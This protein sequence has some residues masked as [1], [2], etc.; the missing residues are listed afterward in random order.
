M[1]QQDEARSGHSGLWRV[2]VPIMAL[3]AGLLFGTSAALAENES[4]ESHPES[5]AGLITERNTAVEQ[6]AD[7][8]ATLQT[9]ID[10]IG[11]RGRPVAAGAAD[12]IAPIVGTAAVRGPAVQVVL[13][14][15]GYTLE[16][17]P[18]GYTVDDVV[19]HQQDVQG[20]I[21]ALWAGGAEAM[22]V[23][24][25]RIIA[26]SA[27][28]CVGNTLYLQG[29][30]Y[31]P[32]Y[33]ITAIGHP[34]TMMRVLADDPT[35]SNYAAWAEILGLGYEVSDIGETE[36]PAFTGTVRAQHASPLGPRPE[37]TRE[38]PLER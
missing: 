23:Q 6:L 27:V 21:N 7:R 34:G 5:L 10:E 35:V 22:M 20:V 36:L 12:S 8:A 31:S 4:L 19:V 9:E 18:Q 16:T 37:P 14:D 15:A 29:R 38:G 11:D 3:G 28:R 25:Q 2:L 17:L 30:V 1:T 32:P 13:D 26:T 33:T 24:D